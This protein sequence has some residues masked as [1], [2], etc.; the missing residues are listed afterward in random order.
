[1]R[2]AAEF[3]IPSVALPPLGTGAGQLGVEASARRMV[4]ILAEH[5]A[6]GR[7]PGTFVIVTES[8][9]DETALREALTALA[10]DLLEVSP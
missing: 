2:R 9:F 10:P 5:L 6:E 8:A 3:G 7:A 1:L 4:P